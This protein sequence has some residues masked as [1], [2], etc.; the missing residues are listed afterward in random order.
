M[1]EE[2][3]KRRLI[4][5]K[6]AAKLKFENMGYSII[7]SDDQ[8]FSFI[9]SRVGLGERKIR[10]TIDEI[11][12]RDL[13]LIKAAWILPKQTKEIWCKKFGSRKW[14]ILDVE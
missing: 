2:V 11:T 4:N 8:P 12:K 7:N 13:E 9:A 3:V 10:I 14:K 6:K 5:A 1:T